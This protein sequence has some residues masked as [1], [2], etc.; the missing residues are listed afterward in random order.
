MARPEKEG[1]TEVEACK[2]SS[3]EEGTWYHSDLGRRNTAGREEKGK[4][5]EVQVLLCPG[6]WTKTQN[7]YVTICERLQE[8][9]HRKPG[10]LT[11]SSP[12]FLREGLRSS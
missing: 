1:S 6:S 11:D 7:L 9:L 10:C 2:A 4:G 8:P 5:S 3:G 12:E